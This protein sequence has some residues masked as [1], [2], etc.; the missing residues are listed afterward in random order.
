MYTL[1]RLIALVLPT[2]L[3]W[4]AWYVLPALVEPA[5]LRWFSGI[6]T[7]LWAL[8][9]YFYQ[10][11]SGLST[12]PGLSS[13]E[14]D[15]LHL[16]LSEIRSRVWRVGAMGLVILDHWDMWSSRNRRLHPPAP[17][18]I[19]DHWDMWSSRNRV[20]QQPPIGQILDHWDMWS[21]RNSSYCNALVLD[22]LDHWD[23]WSSRNLL[24]EQER[25]LKILDH[26]DMWSSRN[27]R[28]H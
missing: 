1:L 18:H 21:S 22:I 26:W 25:M 15:R 17:A 8:E 16:R 14:R 9:F 5:S 12:L 19:L 3:F 2:L 20:G 24:S 11:L 10:R 28:E 23:M 27:A 4:A 6:V 13:R 7:V